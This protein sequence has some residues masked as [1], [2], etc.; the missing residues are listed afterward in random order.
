MPE[1]LPQHNVD[2]SKAEILSQHKVNVEKVANITIFP[3]QILS[4]TWENSEKI[5]KELRE[6]ILKKEKEG[7]GRQ[8]SNVGGFHSE[9]DMLRWDY[10]C[11]EELI[12]RIHQM[13][14]L[15]T[16]VYGLKDDKTVDLS[17]TGWANVMRSGNYHC[18]HNHPNNFWS[19]CYYIDDG[20]PDESIQYNGYFEFLDPRGGSDMH[21]S[22]SLV[23]P[24]YQIIPK[25]GTIIMFP[26]YMQ[27]Y[28]HPYVGL[29]ERISIAFNVRILQ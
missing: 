27:H 10:P 14:G 20:D 8:Q 29:G 19:G 22:E 21:S 13:S 23:C 4:Y 24:R 7:E 18:P 3:T 2:L 9:W 15:M 28:V 17:I 25:A 6:V 12:Q 16:K 11:I 1:T 26:A 5:N